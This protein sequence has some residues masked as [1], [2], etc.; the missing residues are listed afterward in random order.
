MNPP[1]FTPVLFA[2]LLINHTEEGGFTIYNEEHKRKPELLHDTSSFEDF[3]SN[4][5]R[6][7]WVSAYI[8]DIMAVSLIFSQTTSAT[9]DVETLKNMNKVLNDLKETAA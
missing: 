9:Y 4:R 3:L 2:G 7:A 5:H 1:S 6:I 8:P